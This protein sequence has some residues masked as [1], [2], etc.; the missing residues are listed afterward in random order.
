MKSVLIAATLA[1]AF[2]AAPAFAD[3]AGDITKIEEAM[4]TTKLD[5]AGMK[6]AMDN[7]TKAKAAAEAKDET[8]CTTSTAE[9]MKMMGMTG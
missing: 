5:E 2:A 1:L 3:C 9:L 6:A 4:K 8:S 7:L